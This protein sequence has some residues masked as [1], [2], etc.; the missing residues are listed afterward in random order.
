MTGAWLPITHGAE[1][2]KVKNDIDNLGPHIDKEAKLGLV[3]PKYM[4][5]NSIEEITKPIKKNWYRTWCRDC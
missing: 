5:V 3:V 1:Y 4:D 2:K